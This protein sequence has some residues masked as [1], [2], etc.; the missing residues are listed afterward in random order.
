MSATTTTVYAVAKWT[1]S[2]GNVH[3]WPQGVKNNSLAAVRARIARV[4]GETDVNDLTVE[5][6]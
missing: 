6:V 5:T 3:E 1:D 4:L 2:A